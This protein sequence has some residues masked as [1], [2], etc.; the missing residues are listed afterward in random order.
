M[1]KFTLNFLAV[2]MLVLMGSFAMAQTQFTTTFKVDM[3]DVEIF[4]SETDAIFM[5]GPIGWAMP[6][7]SAYYK[8]EPMEAGSMIYTLTLA[9]DSGKVEYKYFRVI[10][11][12]ASW[13]NGEW[14]G[15]PNRK[16]YLTGDT[17][18]NNIWAAKPQEVTFNLDM[19]EAD[20]FDPT[21]DAIYIGGSLANGWAQPGT[22][23]A[24]KMMVTEENIDIY[25]ITLLVDKG[26]QAF[27]YFRIIND[28][29]SWDNG[30]WAGEPNRVLTVD[31]LAIVVDDVWADINA[32]IFD[33][34]S[35]FTY[36]MY[37][38]PANSSLTLSNISDVN[39][40]DVYDVTGKLI[41]TIATE[42]VE[43]VTIDVTDL[44][45]GVYIL[46]ATN[47]TGVQTTKFVK[48]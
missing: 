2:A 18:Y 44:N 3:T 1:K 26:E 13:D 46:N 25:T 16:V 43:N 11:G 42:G 19:S 20:P 31:T 34:K 5:S 36:K 4:N 24:Y 12:E 6:G 9:V 39:R 47:N 23:D 22:V 7:D 21:T 45:T 38:N 32:G 17:E 40:I 30:E 8:M 10:G 14:T 48:K 28:E 33:Q 35:P 37:P 15:D 41:R 29:P 27:K